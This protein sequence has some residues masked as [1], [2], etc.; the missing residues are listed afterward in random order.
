M[1]ALDLLIADHNRVRGLF[2]RYQAAEEAGDTSEM[3]DL[4]ATPEEQA[5]ITGYLAAHFPPNTTRAPHLVP[6]DA[7]IA[8]KEW[9]V[10]TLGQ[11]SR[12]P[13]EAQT[14]AELA[15]RVARTWSR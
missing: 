9:Q 1:N 13:V 6:G 2:A 11:R 12:D 3:I 5:E 4:S 14:V 10:P 15:G 7:E 8:F